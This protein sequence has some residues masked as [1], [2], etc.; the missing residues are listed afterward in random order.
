MRRFRAC[1]RSA[2]ILAA[3]AGVSVSA[4]RLTSLPVDAA[5]PAAIQAFVLVELLRSGI[6]GADAA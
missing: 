1:C 4:M 6:S 3:S 5:E 2:A